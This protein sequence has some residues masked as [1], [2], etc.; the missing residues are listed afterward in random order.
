MT[1]LV[2]IP[3]KSN[4]GDSLPEAPAVS[5]SRPPL[6]TAGAP[7][8]TRA[9]KM[10][11]LGEAS[12]EVVERV[13]TGLMARIQRDLS[14]IQSKSKEL[15]EELAFLRA[16]KPDSPLIDSRQRRLAESLEREEKLKGDL[17]E[18]KAKGAG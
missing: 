9:T 7:S 1:N 13:R 17:D 6:K 5:P 12:A 11:S 10:Q 15:A 14:D 8:N 4:S 18:L 2:R 16:H 3:S